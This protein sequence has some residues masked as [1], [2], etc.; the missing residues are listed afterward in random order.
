MNA[1]LCPKCR[2]LGLDSD[3]T[4]RL[5]HAHRQSVMTGEY[6]EGTVELEVTFSFLAPITSSLDLDPVQMATH[7]R[8]HW[9]E[10]P[11][12]LERVLQDALTEDFDLAV[13]P[14]ST[15]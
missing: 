15:L 1:P 7:M 4:D 11:G 9:I 3:C 13:R 2:S 12:R 14:V 10:E 5:K 8:E 6:D